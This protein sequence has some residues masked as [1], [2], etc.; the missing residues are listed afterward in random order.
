[1]GFN[2]LL[3]V[4]F[5]GIAVFH[6][7]HVSICEMEYDAERMA[8]EI[9]QR[10][11]LDDLEKEIRTE[12]KKPTLD[13]LYPNNGMSTDEIFEE[14]LEK[15]LKVY[16]NGKSATYKYLG[17][18]IERNVAYMYIEIEKV[19]KFRDISVFSDILTATYDDQINL[20]HV[21]VNDELKSLK[22]H[23]KKFRDALSF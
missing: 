22:L 14:Y 13:I 20:V 23:T 21:E 8:L 11:F 10:I 17:H 2:I 5:T 12:L 4:F 1:M 3:T 16:L 6:P 7:I 9:T 15:H 19:K 18:E